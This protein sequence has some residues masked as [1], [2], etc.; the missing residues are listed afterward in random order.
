[1]KW[2]RNIAQASRKTRFEEWPYEDLGMDEID[3]RFTKIHSEQM[4]NR[5][6]MPIIALNCAYTSLLGLCT[7]Q[8]SY[9]DQPTCKGK[10]IDEGNRKEIP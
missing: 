5:P 7:V 4:S 10:R 9:S 3:L 6:K 8:E 1:M 2:A